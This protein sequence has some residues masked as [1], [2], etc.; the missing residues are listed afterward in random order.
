MGMEWKRLA[1]LF[2]SFF[3]ISP[4]TFGGGYAMI[5]LIE[6]EVVERRKWMTEDEICD[7]LS[8]AG[9]APGGIGVN[10]AAFIGYRLAGVAG[11]TAAVTGIGLPT[12]II[13]FALS[14]LFGF[15]SHLPMVEAAFKGIHAAVIGLIIVA[16]YRMAKTAIMDK[17]TLILTLLSTLFLLDFHIHPILLILFGLVAGIV[18]AKFKEK[19]GLNGTEETD[20]PPQTK[21]SYAD[22]YIGD[23]I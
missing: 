2:W 7:V 22:Y 21:Y 4:V 8:V 3:R 16:A 18:L 10:A 19:I 12:F 14:L 9:T 11:A 1:A 13:V 23:G 6:R 5:P 20:S 17:T 15:F